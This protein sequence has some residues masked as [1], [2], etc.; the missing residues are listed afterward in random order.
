M[1]WALSVVEVFCQPRGV[2]GIPSEQTPHI[3]PE[4]EGEVNF[5]TTLDRLALVEGIFHNSCRRVGNW[6]RGVISL[7]LL[8]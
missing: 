3:P 7:Q 4:K 8:I 5:L 6:R 2:A 1:L